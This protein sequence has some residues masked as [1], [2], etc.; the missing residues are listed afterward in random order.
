MDIRY[1]NK[2]DDQVRSRV[3][4]VLNGRRS[5]IAK[6][7]AMAASDQGIIASIL[8]Q[9]ISMTGGRMRA[10]LLQDSQFFLPTH[11]KYKNSRM[12]Q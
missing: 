3:F 5:V 12:N 10:L 9:T 11:N 4:D 2:P 8:R 1:K 6:D 7:P